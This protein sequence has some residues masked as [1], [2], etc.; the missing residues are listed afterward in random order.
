MIFQ[1][2]RTALNPIRPVGEQIADVLRRHAAVPRAEVR[3][4][5]V[6][7]LTRVAIPDPGR[8]Y[9]A[10]PFELSGGLCQRVM[11]SIAL[12]CSPALL[13]A[14]EPT[15]GLDVT[16]QA[17]V[18]DLVAELAAENHMATLLIT[19]DLGMAAERCDRIVVMHAGHVV[20]VAPTEELF[21]APRHPYTARLI[22]ATPRPGVKLGDLAAIPGGL[23]DLRGE[24]GPCRYRARCERYEAACDDGP[25]PLS[26]LGRGH[27]V[28]RRSP[29][30]RAARRA[31]RQPALRRA[32]GPR[33]TTR[34]LHAVE[35]VSFDIKHAECVGLV[36]ESGCGKST[37]VRLITRLLDPTEGR[38]WFDGQYLEDVPAARFASRPERA[39][40]QMVFQDPTD[41]LNPRFTAF[42]TIADPLRRLGRLAGP[43]ALAERVHA[44]AD[45]VGLP[46]ELLGRFPHQLSG[47]QKQRVGIA[48]AVA[49]E[50][51]LLVLDEPTS[52]LDVSVQAVILKLLDD[53]R[54]RL[55]MSYLFVS[56]DL[57][58]VRLL[59]DRVLGCTSAR[60]SSRARHRRTER[61]RHPYT[62]ALR[63]RCP[64]GCPA[65]WP[66]HPAIGGA[67]EPDRS[68]ADDMPVLRALPGGFD[69]CRTGCR[70]QVERGE[71]AVAVTSRTARRRA[72]SARRGG[73]GAGA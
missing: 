51:K 32:R 7:M 43:A 17:A 33:G 49:L 48:R 31:R 67:A 56:H 70:A 47:G 21:R 63:P 4:R 15:T 6:D 59:A 30:D 19:H 45:L 1:N 12:A 11:I 14:D 44:L 72:G 36:G 41:S 3:K 16:T 55:G 40:I 2:P 52:A 71:H 66:A 26:D 61:P 57:N 54:R 65:R 18:M 46:R 73:D 5:A 22:A 68:L 50:P 62:R 38:I 37:L 34:W 35:D 28:A 9:A 58:I 8:R 10:Y 42:H 23:P 13:I 20:E 27:L 29:C 64:A 25:L 24:L 69:R 39:R 53:L 60:S